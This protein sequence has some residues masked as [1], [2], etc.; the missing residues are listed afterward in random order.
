MFNRFAQKP[1]EYCG[2]FKR[3]KCSLAPTIYYL[4]NSI[5]GKDKAN[6]PKLF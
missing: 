6:L 4:Q 1:L 5:I 2:I 3:I